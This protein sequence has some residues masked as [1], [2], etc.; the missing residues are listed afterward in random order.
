MQAKKMCVFLALPMS[1]GVHWSE[2]RKSK[3]IEFYSKTKC[4]VD[5]G[6]QMARQY[7]V[8]AGTRRWRVAVFFL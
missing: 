7:S 4:G 5:V 8:K 6:D 2:K 3:I 1:V